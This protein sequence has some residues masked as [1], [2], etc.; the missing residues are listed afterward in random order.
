MRSGRGQG[1]KHPKLTLGR[2][3]C[4][5]ELHDC[6]AS[7]PGIIPIAKIDAGTEAF[8]VPGSMKVNIELAK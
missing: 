7:S 1:A 6:H 2:T 3:P 5:D 8:N 4:N